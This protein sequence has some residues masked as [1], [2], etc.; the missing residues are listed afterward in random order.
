LGP[1]ELFVRPSNDV[2]EIGLCGSRQTH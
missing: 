2:L 1:A